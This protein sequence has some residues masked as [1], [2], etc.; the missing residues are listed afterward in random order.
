MHKANNAIFSLSI[1]GCSLSE[2]TP[3]AYQPGKNCHRACGLGTTWHVFLPPWTSWTRNLPSK[4][5]ASNAAVPI[6]WQS[7]FLRSCL[8]QNKRPRHQGGLVV[9]RHIA[10]FFC[11]MQTKGCDKQSKEATQIH[12]AKKRKFHSSLMTE[13]NRNSV[14]GLISRNWARGRSN[15][16]PQAAQGD[17]HSLSQVRCDFETIPWQKG[18]SY[19]LIEFISKLKDSFWLLDIFQTLTKW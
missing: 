16:R 15:F 3:F 12:K 14:T 5:W 2:F 1:S 6:V 11:V 19:V 13:I 10:A 8:T 7:C 17:W 18:K 4:M 9:V